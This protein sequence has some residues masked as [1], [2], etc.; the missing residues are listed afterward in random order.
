[1]AEIRKVDPEAMANQAKIMDGLIGQ[2]SDSVRDI[3][4]LKDEIDAMWDGLANETFNARW[5]NDLNKYN[6]LQVV[7][8]SYRRAIEEAATKYSDY[9]NEIASIV[10]DNN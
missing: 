10:K 9:E 7:L 6:N 5:E 2:W 8:E 3:T 1:M 4:T